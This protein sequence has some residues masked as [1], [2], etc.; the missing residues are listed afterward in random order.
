MDRLH[1]G[2]EKRATV[3]LAGPGYG[4][5]ALLALF[6]R[7]SGEDS[8]WLSL[9]P[10]DRDPFVFFRNIVQGFA[11]HVPEMGERS[12]RAYE[13]LRS[14]PLEAERLADVF[15]DD[16]EEL[17]G[18]R[19]V[20]VVDG[21]EH[22]EGSSSCV[23]ALRRL[24]LCLPG[25]IH[26]VLAGRS[27]P[28]VGIENGSAG[29]AVTRIEGDELLFTL[30]E[31]RTLLRDAFGLRVRPDTVGRIHARTRGWV[32]A[33]QLLR[34]TA[35]LEASATDPP[36]GLFARTESE[37][38]D[39]FSE[40]VF[41][42]ET[43]EV[44]EFLLGSCPPQVV[45]PEVCSEVL[46]KFEAG[47]L[48]ADLARRHMFI[49]A[50]EGRGSYYAYDPLFHDFLRRKLRAARGPEGSRALELRYGRAFAQRG[51]FPRALAHFLAAES[52]KETADLLQRRGDALLRAGMSG[53]VREAALFLSLRGAR[54]PIAAALLGEACRLAGDHT[55]A[56]AHFQAA[57]DARGEG[58][59]EI[60]GHDR[61]AAFQGLAY[62]LSRLG[63]MARAEVSAA[64][65]LA[66]VGSEDPGLRARVLNTLALVRWRQKR[67]T[68][69]LALWEE[70][71]VLAR[72]AADD[73]LVLMIAHNLG[74]PHAA[75]GD[76]SR[77]R[78]CFR[79]LT[80]PDNPRLGPEEGAAYLNL[81]RIARLQGDYVGAATLLG[82]AREIAQMRRL[83]GLLADVL[84]EE[85]NLC[86]DRGDLESASE[87]YA[88]AG[89]ALSDLGR[90]DLLDSLAGEEA[91]LAAR[92]GNHGEAETLAAEAVARR[93]AAG[94]EEGVAAALL[95]LGE[96]RVCARAASRA[97]RVLAEA[98]AYFSASGRAY[99]EC[100]ARLW[101]ALAR[102]L[103]RD[104]HRAVAQAL[105]A[106]E[107]AARYDYRAQVLR[108]AA[109][110]A[111]FRDLL[112]SLADAPG[113]LQMASAGGL[114]EAGAARP[115]ATPSS[116]VPGAIVMV[117]DAVGAVDLTVRLLGPIE[118]YR[119]AAHRIPGDP[120]VRRALGAFCCLAVARD[121]RV[122]REQLAEA[123]WG[124]ARPSAIERNFHST[125]SLLRRALNH[126]HHV[127]KNFIRCE[128]GA[129]LLNPAYRYDIDV[130]TF[131]EL[132]R[133][134]RR[135]ASSQDAAGAL[136]DY[137]AAIALHRGPL[138]DGERDDWIGAPRAFYETLYFAALG[139]AAA[140][141]LRR[142]DA[143][144]E[145]ACFRIIVERNPLDER[146]SCRLMRALGEIGD[147][148]GLDR[149]FSRLRQALAD[150]RGAGP[151]AGTRRAYQ[152]VLK[153]MREGRGRSVPAAR[154]PARPA[155]RRRP[156]G[157]R[158]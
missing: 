119:D 83:Q 158:T 37:I 90:Q 138:M 16:A 51:D 108:I 77:A 8:V 96:V 125:I 12:L 5:T 104:R 60:T 30:D 122:T 20:L 81:S 144:R 71:L 103:E 139:E 149:E 117:A 15:I 109:Q 124:N 121:H 154:K 129:Y 82:D 66:E 52:L 4:K 50:L 64:Q 115:V 101:L 40:E 112:A 54:P 10:S 22:L 126:G 67:L 75:A 89:A 59:G 106:L 105:R 87:R 136:A 118:V 80:G 47:S 53:A 41:A 147:R 24:A 157:A 93:R 13:D 1:A 42:S 135:N 74:L 100:M 127:P 19:I 155:L 35:R 39:Y 85:G 9:D 65:A 63:E 94:D 137:A 38:F 70:A 14:H 86:R 7:E 113:Y 145:A 34:Q 61:A 128:Q 69:A 140:L 153:R 44:R 146:V 2:L 148:E 88:R 45:D 84:E 56:I 68:E 116:G 21:V 76:F 27:L 73:H 95:A 133:S 107:I 132:V 23:Q 97:I 91:I 143:E 48:L 29:D 36:E 17:L 120:G 134:A 46:Q 79:S 123:L 3:V 114:W 141:R 58:A 43:V 32:T 28:D 11:E 62:S 92:R 78:E 99:Q 33:L 6:L 152:D 142:E 49:S 72:Q 31:T 151:R 98:A 130:E 131:E 110:D 102:Q 150:D 156:D 25:A 18:G 26:L 55:A 111:D 57:L